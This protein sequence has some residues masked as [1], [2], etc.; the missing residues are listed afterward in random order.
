LS[1]ALRSPN[2][3]RNS[4]TSR[5]SAC[6]RSPISCKQM[7]QGTQQGDPRGMRRR[8]QHRLAYGSKWQACQ[9]MQYLL[10]AACIKFHCKWCTAWCRPRL[11][12]SSC[13]SLFLT[14][15]A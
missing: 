13:Q 4:S 5:D 1:A 15:A 9:P 14:A 2:S 10:P 3:L 12:W 7:Q 8:V 6:R 11:K